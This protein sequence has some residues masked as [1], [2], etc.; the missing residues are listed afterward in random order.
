METTTALAVTPIYAAWLAKF[1]PRVIRSEEQNESYI[2]ALY[3]LEQ[4]H[5]R[6]SPEEAELAD[7]LTLL[8][9]TF[10]EAHYQLTRCSPRE[11][12]AFLIDQHGLRQ[13]DLTDVFDTPSIAS[14]VLSGKRELSNEHTAA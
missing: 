3:E 10:E 7:L 13:K 4:H 1:S 5:D 14:E 2:Q 8:I 12:V 6:W 11:A 9:E